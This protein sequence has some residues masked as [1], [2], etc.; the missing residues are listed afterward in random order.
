M[1]FAEYYFAILFLKLS[2]PWFLQCDEPAQDTPGRYRFAMLRP[3]IVG[4]SS[5][6]SVAIF[7]GMN[8]PAKTSHRKR[9]IWKS[10]I[11]SLNFFWR[12]IP[13]RMDARWRPGS[14]HSANMGRIFRCQCCTT[15][16]ICHPRILM[17]PGNEIIS[18]PGTGVGVHWISWSMPRVLNLPSAVQDELGDE[19]EIGTTSGRPG[20]NRMMQFN[21]YS[22]CRCRGWL[23][24]SQRTGDGS[25]SPHNPGAQLNNVN[26]AR[27]IRK[28]CLASARCR[29]SIFETTVSARHYAF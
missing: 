12:K 11:L 3:G 16:R 13:G 17:R 18:L 15:P 8:I 20:I 24:R 14:V 4:S 29:Q 26:S 2:V 19:D 10:K 1:V 7:C 9:N 27:D 25:M 21:S 5:R 23:W 6:L 22:T 28:R